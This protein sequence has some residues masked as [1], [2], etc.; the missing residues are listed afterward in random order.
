MY[1]SDSKLQKK[2][3]SDEQLLMKGVSKNECD[4]EQHTKYVQPVT[5]HK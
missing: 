3:K 5:R 1:T 2:K 4:D